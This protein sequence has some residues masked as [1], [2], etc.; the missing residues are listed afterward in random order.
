MHRE[1][2]SPTEKRIA[3]AVFEEAVAAECEEILAE[4]KQRAAALVDPDDMFSLGKW[5]A[6]EERR[7]ARRYDFRYSEL[8]YVF[9]DLLREGRIAEEEL[10]GL[11]PDKLERIRGFAAP[12]PSLTPA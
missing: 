2:W 11:S 1:D 8:P 5:V 12:R 4:F 9:G 3:R 10:Q 6:E 7:L